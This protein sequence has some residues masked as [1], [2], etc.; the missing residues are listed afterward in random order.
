VPIFGDPLLDSWWEYSNEGL[1]L[2]QLR[3]YPIAGDVPDWPTTD[4]TSKGNG[5]P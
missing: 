1:K 4:C 5:G 2:A 3:F